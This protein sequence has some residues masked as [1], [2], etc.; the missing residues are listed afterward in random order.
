MNLLLLMTTGMSLKK[1]DEIGQLSRE[2]NIYQQLGEKV[3]HVYIFSYGKNEEKYVKNYSNLSVISK[4]KWFPAL[5]RGNR[6]LEPIYQFLS[7]ILKK[8]LFRH[9]DIVKT[10]QFN[11]S[12][13]GIKLKKK[14]GCKLLVRMGYYHTLDKKRFS[15]ERDYKEQVRLEKKLFAKADGIIV[16]NTVAKSFIHKT[17][18]LNGNIVH[19]IPNYID[20][21]LF[22]PLNMGK[23]YDIIFVGRFIEIKNLRK[24]L[25]AVIGLNLR[26]LFIG[27]GYLKKD[28]LCFAKDNR[29]DLTIFDRVDNK[30]LPLYYNAAKIFILPSLYESNPK[31]LLE[32]MACGCSC[33]GTDVSGINNIIEHKVNGYLCDIESDSIKQ[34]I[35]NIPYNKTFENSI[36]KNARKFISENYALRNSLN[37]EV[38]LYNCLN[39]RNNKI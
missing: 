35:T 7:I 29:I 5:R 24:L 36:G 31:T 9:I 37:K 16:T 12:D 8:N 4:F 18:K 15:N 34:T 26:L 17:H 11:G 39:F 22:K 25:E 3:G 14:F 23:K 13:F 27:K 32:A 2:L 30:N 28:L 10:N 21:E 19:Y 38:E 33:I 20:T 1:W 6:F